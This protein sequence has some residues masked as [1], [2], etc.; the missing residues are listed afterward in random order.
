M[1]NQS[2]REHTS[3]EL[4]LL[5]YELRPIGET[6]QWWGTKWVKDDTVKGGMRLLPCGAPTVGRGLFCSPTHSLDKALDV[7]ERHKQDMRDWR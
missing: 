4:A 7:C 6:C 1:T 2:A 5:E 3:H